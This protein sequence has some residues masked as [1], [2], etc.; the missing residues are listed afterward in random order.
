M[1]TDVLSSL[2]SNS[3]QID[4]S[5]SLQT[6]FD[7]ISDL[8]LPSS[9]PNTLIASCFDTTLSQYDLTTFKETSLLRGH[10]KGVW[11]CDAHPSSSTLIS[12]S[13]DN[14]IIYWDLR[15][16]QP[17]HHLKTHSNAIYDVQFSS[18]GRYFASCSKN[19][20]CIWD[21]NNLSKPVDTLR[22]DKDNNGFI[23]CINFFDNDSKVITGYVDG[24]VILHSFKSNEDDVMLTLK[25]DYPSY[26]QEELD[27]AKAVYAIHK[28][29]NG[30]SN[31]IILSHSDG[32]V[33]LFDIV[34]N[35]L[36]Q[37]DAFYYFTSPVTCAN[38]SLDDKR[39]IGCGKDRTAEIWKINTHSA[40]DYTLSGH[41]NII[42]ACD[43]VSDNV[44]VTGSYDCS[45]KLW[46]LT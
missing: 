10:T 6:H 26:E 43:F 15:S 40:I 27:Y 36:K 44:V 13:N 41:R 9:L 11:T 3:K 25:C 21:T 5:H 8:S 14:T 32:S 17:L 19:T 34:G 24:T 1:K 22:Q 35:A 31:S 4:A 33:R 42:S 16:S 7:G 18:D 38:C 37:R 29:R 46:T 2:I 12:G 30:K 28:F 20:I 45:I 39:L 23:Y